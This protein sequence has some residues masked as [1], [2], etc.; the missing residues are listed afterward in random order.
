M[1]LMTA[2]F[3]CPYCNNKFMKEKTFMVHVCEKK[4]RHLAKNEKHVQLGLVAFVKF[5]KTVQKSNSE[6]TYD[7]F[8]DSPY[9]NAFIKF[10]SFISNV[11][12]LYP[13]QYIDYIIKSGVKIDHWCRE[14]IYEEYVLNLIKTEPMEVA[15]K[16]SVDHMVSWAQDHGSVWNHYFLHVTTNRATFD[17]K[18]GKISP[19]LILNCETGRKLL[20]SFTDEQLTMVS[21]AMDPRFWIKKFKDHKDDVEFI[22]NAVKEF[23]I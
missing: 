7:D 17:I 21:A 19:W 3:T 13:E 23:K 11:N 1:N 5:Y 12:P 15:F 9:Y 6:K 14:T 2:P 8:A 18:D 22:K 10:G 4:R 20:D 16:R